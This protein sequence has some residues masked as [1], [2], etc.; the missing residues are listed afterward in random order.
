[1]TDLAG[2]RVTLHYIRLTWKED[3]WPYTQSC[4]WVTWQEE[5]WPYIESCL[6]LTWQE[7][8][9]PYVES[10]LRLTWHEEST[11]RAVYDWP[12]SKKGDHTLT[13]V[14]EWPA[15]K[16]GDLTLTSVYDWSARKKSDLTL[17][18]VYDWPARKKSG[19][20]LTS[21]YDWPARTRVIRYELCFT[22]QN[23]WLPESCSWLTCHEE[24]RG[25][26]EET[27]GQGDDWEHEEQ[28]FGGGRVTPRQQAVRQTNIKIHD[29]CLFFFS[30]SKV[31]FLNFLAGLSIFLHCTQTYW[32]A[33]SLALHIT[34]ISVHFTICQLKGACNIITLYYH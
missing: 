25:S 23:W 1:M 29:V 34:H 24:Q 8:R 33:T 17:T 6:R 5:R 7:Q 10:C 16:K 12:A 3:E 30:S 31:P 32:I 18:S 15:R 20:T 19:L 11:Q 27:G 4:L 21:A 26:V 9:W 2:R 13:A 28:G 22:E 14:Y